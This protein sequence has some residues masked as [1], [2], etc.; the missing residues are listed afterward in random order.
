[1]TWK[2]AAAFTARLL[3]ALLFL[4][5]A[6]QKVADPGPASDL[7]ALRGWPPW[8]LWPA[9]AFN[10]AA[11][12]LLL[13]G[14][15]VP[16]TALALA[17]YCAVTSLFHFQPDEPWQMTIFVKNWAIAGGCLALSALGPGRWRL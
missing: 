3:I 2:D 11:G 5:G 9:L 15:L 16:A 17:A 12:L 1:M 13:A 8:L 7:L 4:G 14:R 10:L 6:A